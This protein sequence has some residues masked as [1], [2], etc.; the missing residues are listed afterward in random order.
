MTGMGK[1]AKSLSIPD[2]PENV[3][4][5]V[6]QEKPKQED[7]TNPAHPSG[8]LPPEAIGEA[9]K[10]FQRLWRLKFGD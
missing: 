2:S 3:A 10:H 7:A 9:V 8:E 1:Y 6:L 5:A 4:K